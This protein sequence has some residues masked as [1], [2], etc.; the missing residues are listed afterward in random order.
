MNKLSDFIKSITA[1]IIK[2][3]V[4]TVFTETIRR[5]LPINIQ[6]KVTFVCGVSLMYAT[7]KSQ[8]KAFQIRQSQRREPERDPQ[9]AHRLQEPVRSLTA[10]VVRH[11]QVQQN[12]LQAVLPGHPVRAQPKIPSVRNSDLLIEA[13]KIRK[14]RDLD[15]YIFDF[16]SPLD[17]LRYT[18]TSKANNDLTIRS[19][20]VVSSNIERLQVVTF[21][22][23]IKIATDQKIPISIIHDAQ[24]TEPSVRLGII[25]IKINNLFLVFIKK[26]MIIQ[27][28][29]CLLMICLLDGRVMLFVIPDFFL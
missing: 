11:P 15:E 20:I 24:L 22:R 7:Y 6:S 4:L 27:Q 16:L 9:A 14:A 3:S 21:F 17:I 29:L 5:Y 1:P 10:F 2:L 26:I 28:D 13:I 18:V 25:L 23:F 12:N 8:L 19:F